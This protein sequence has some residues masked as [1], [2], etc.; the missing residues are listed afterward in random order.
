MKKLIVFI[1]LV[2]FMAI[3][4]NFETIIQNYLTLNKDQYQLSSA[5]LSEFVIHNQHYARSTKTNN[6]YVT[7]KVSN[8][9]IH[10]GVSV[11]S[12]DNA[13]KVRTAKV[14]FIRQAAQKINTTTPAIT[15]QQA[16]SKAA[17]YLKIDNRG[18]LQVI[19]QMNEQ[20]F[21][22]NAANISQE[23]IPVKLM[24]QSNDD[25]T[26]LRLVWD[27][28]IY[29]LDAS[30]WYSIR[31]DAVNGNLLSIL[32]WVSNCKFDDS[33]SDNHYDSKVKTFG[34]QITINKSSYFAFGPNDGSQYNVLP[35]P[36]ESPNHG[37]TALLSQPANP[38]ASPFGWHDTNGVVGPEF[39]STRGNNVRARADLAGNNTGD[40]T[41]GG[42]TLNFNFPFSLNN[43]PNTYIPAST[44][45][46][47]YWNNIIHDVFHF[48]GF[49]E[50]SGNF[51]QT[52]YS[53]QGLG[54]DFVNADNQDGS[55][56]NNAN[57]A[58]P[59]DGS[60]PRMQM[61]NWTTGAGGALLSVP[62]GALQG[63]YSVAP[64]TFGASL[65]TPVT[66]DFALVVDD[67][68]GTTTDPNDGCD[69]IINSSSLAGKIV[70]MRRGNCQ[71]GTKVLAAQNQGAT[72]VIVVN[73][74][75][76]NP[77]SMTPGNDGG[78]VTIPSVMISQ[79]LGQQIIDALNGNQS[80]SG[81][82]SLTNDPV[83]TS[84]M[85][86]GVITHEY[87][88]G[89][90]NRL[91]GGAN[92]SNCLGNAEQMGEG[93]SDYFA[94]ILTMKPTD[95]ANQ[96]RGMGSY[97]RNQPITGNGIRPAPYS[98]SF[99]VNN[100]TFGATNN[101]SISQPHGIGFVWASMLW[102]M[103]WDMIDVYGFN[104][105]FFTGNGGN[106]KALQLVVDGLKLQP[107][108]PGFVDGRN[109]ILEADLLANNS[110]NKCLIWRAFARRGLGV[111]AS[112]GSSTNRFD[113]IEAFD[114][115]QECTLSTTGFNS[116]DFFFYPNPTDG[117]L[118]IVAKN[119]V[120]TSL[121]SV[122]D[123]NGRLVKEA[124]IDLLNYTTFDISN[125][126]AGV[127][128]IKISNDTIDFQTKIIKK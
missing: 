6:V 90:S 75:G 57:F 106:N 46:L 127:Y 28:S 36:N 30:H 41:Q 110:D 52:N 109:A 21:L 104:P 122:Y 38:I 88:H 8:I 43:H 111:S 56:T 114:I 12:I 55:G 17:D 73:N 15:P 72:A 87:G 71:F 99:T 89:I 118:Q 84:S 101:Q 42:S 98:R 26:Q 83:L 45:N 50:A 94:L 120:G 5:D 25:Q 68:S 37:S 44:T 116:N 20:Q 125:L 126:N 62:A 66:G 54:N 4:Q 81:T 31:I 80:I 70:V 123:V 119:A 91:T 117:Q 47:F 13:L 95:T 24:Y 78:S 105:N 97:L 67:N 59:P 65:S 96:I 51:Q 23:S 100:F 121:I 69:N 60:S 63:T 35:M 9:E 93:W 48:Y 64:S 10:Q 76:A 107:C 34:K 32:D 7:Q 11:F 115:P 85:D 3:S 61:F 1:S 79:A 128:I 27:L 113:Q 19:N 16:I 53:G 86:S 92:N 40:E 58:T 29:L 74:T 102:D 124:Q 18:N 77:I 39:T 33:H 2:P 112:Q 49:D 82:L 108:N 22:F 103:T 14:G